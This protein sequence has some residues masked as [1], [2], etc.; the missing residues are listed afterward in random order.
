VYLPSNEY[1]RHA[2]WLGSSRFA[3]TTTRAMYSDVAYAPFGEPYAQS[4]TTDLSYTGMNS[5][6]SGGLYDSCS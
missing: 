5:D 6:T 2:D 3:S 4:G 1:Y